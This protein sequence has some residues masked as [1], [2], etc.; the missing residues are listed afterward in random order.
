LRVEDRSVNTI[1]NLEILYCKSCE[2][3]YKVDN[4]RRDNLI[5]KKLDCPY[6]GAKNIVKVDSLISVTIETIYS[7]FKKVERF[8]E[9]IDKMIIKIDELFLKMQKINSFRE[10]IKENGLFS[11]IFTLYAKL[12]VIIDD[13]ENHIMEFQ[14]SIFKKTKEMLEEFTSTKRVLRFSLLQQ[15]DEFYEYLNNILS[16]F[17]ALA[18]NFR[19]IK[20]V[21]NKFEIKAKELMPLLSKREMGPLLIKIINIDRNNY[22]VLSLKNLYVIDLKKRRVTKQIAVNKI[23]NIRAS[24]K[25]LRQGLE[26]ETLDGRRIFI[27]IPSEEINNALTAINSVLNSEV[28][29]FNLLVNYEVERK[30]VKPITK[31]L[32]TK[33]HESK[34]QILSLIKEMKR[35]IKEMFE[36]KG[37]KVTNSQVSEANDEYESLS[38]D[39]KIFQKLLEDLDQK[40]ESGLL[41]VQEYL[42]LKHYLLKQLEKVKEK[43]V[44]YKR[45]KEF[46]K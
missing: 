29:D 2:S 34:I 20:M 27:R 32:R 42:K 3:V 41:T 19:S 17:S 16:Q 38:V 13:L 44:I 9:L 12:G 10:I 28:S 6:C 39:A 45:S 33:I 15:I 18:E 31:R 8:R 30:A 25:L 43:S 5:Y 14:E 22:L 7:Y 24:K 40:Y 11:E 35:T 36:N 21:V 46:P 37:L 26:I 23:I 1:N 4:I